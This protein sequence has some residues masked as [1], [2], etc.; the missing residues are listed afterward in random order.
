M[1]RIVFFLFFTLVWMQ[2]AQLD[3]KIASFIGDKEYQIQKNLIHILFKDEQ[4]TKFIIC[5]K[6]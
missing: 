2:A 1:V 5:N 3:D 4:Q 6:K